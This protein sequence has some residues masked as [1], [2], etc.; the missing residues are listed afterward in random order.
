MSMFSKSHL[1]PRSFARSSKPSRCCQVHSLWE[2]R[3]QVL[4]SLLCGFPLKPP[5]FMSTKDCGPSHQLFGFMASSTQHEWG[6]V[7]GF[8]VAGS[9]D[10]QQQIK[11]FE[12]WVVGQ[13]VCLPTVYTCWSLSTHQSPSDR[14]PVWRLGP[15]G[16][17]A[18]PEIGSMRFWLLAFIGLVFLHKGKSYTKHWGDMTPRFPREDQWRW[19]ALCQ[20][21]REI[22]GRPFPHIL[23]PIPYLS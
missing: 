4:A 11:G 17:N 9:W 13:I 14:Y 22:Y 12:P 6:G 1:K 16:L 7:G 3:P 23:R 21:R 10:M 8:V 2:T 19:P 5:T 20:P 18:N 15:Q